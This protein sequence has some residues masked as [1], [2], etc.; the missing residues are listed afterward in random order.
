MNVAVRHPI[1]SLEDFLVWEARQEVKFEYDGFEPVGMA[2][3]TI[4]HARIQTNLAISVGSRLRGGPC[5][6]LGSDMKLVSM[7]RARYPD[8]QIV[9]GSG[10]PR[11][12]FTTTPVV[13]FEVVSPGDE[14]RDRVVKLNE[15]KWIMSLQTYVIL[16]QDRPA[17]TVLRR[18]GTGWGA[19]EAVGPQDVL[20][21]P[22]VGID[23]PLAEL[24]LG[25]A[26]P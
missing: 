20:V 19:G 5:E 24:Y 11:A 6:F 7:N 17:A 10:E 12:T 25:V 15:Y 2:G 8:G 26:E 4:N 9:C 22:E 14:G 3:G 23:V 18:A 21:L 1:M 13:V 16:E